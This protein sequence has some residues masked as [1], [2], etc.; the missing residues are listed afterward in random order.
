VALALGTIAIGLLVHW[1]A[2]PLPFIVRDVL[3]DALWAMMVAWWAGALAPDMRPGVRSGLALAFCW[4]VEFS[5]LYH[6]PELDAVRRTTPGQLVL[7]SGFD[8]R[9]LGAYAMGV[10]AALL[11]E[12][13]IRR[14]RAGA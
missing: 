12:R 8:V 13:A 6:L 14:S 2:T 11:L 1:R 7:G 5:Q 9:D 10:L 3:G 4:A